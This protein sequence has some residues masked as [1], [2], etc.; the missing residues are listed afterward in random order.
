MKFNYPRELSFA[1]PDYQVGCSGTEYPFIGSDGKTYL[2]VWNKK[3]WHHAY[4]CFE[5]DLFLP[6]EE[7]HL[8]E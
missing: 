1:H 2:Y 6:E 7:Y 4:Y 5:S 3:L 8:I